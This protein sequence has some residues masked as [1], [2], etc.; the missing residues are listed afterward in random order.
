MGVLTAV[1]IAQTVQF[2]TTVRGALCLSGALFPPPR[3]RQRHHS[4]CAPPLTQINETVSGL[5][6]LQDGL[7]TIVDDNNQLLAGLSNLDSSMA[8]LRAAAVGCGQAPDGGF[9][10]IAALVQT[11]NAS[12]ALVPNELAQTISTLQSALST[13]SGV[14]SVQN[15]GTTVFVGVAASLSIYL[16]CLG[17]VGSTLVPKPCCASTFRVCNVLLIVVFLLTWI[18]AGVLMIISIVGSD[19]C[20]APPAAI[21]SIAS[22]TTGSGA[23]A[24]ATLLYYT[25]CVAADGRIIAP[26][27]TAGAAYSAYTANA[28]FASFMPALQNWTTPTFRL[29]CAVQ[30]TAVTNANGQCMN[31]LSLLG[32]DAG[33]VAINNDYQPLATTLC[34]TGIFAL[35]NVWALATFGCIFMLTL[36]AAATRICWRHP[37]DLSEEEG[38]SENTRLTS[39]WGKGANEAAAPPPQGSAAPYV[40]MASKPAPA[41]YYTAVPRSSQAYAAVPVSDWGR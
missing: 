31:A 10:T 13:G 38:D 17:L 20:A 2:K 36:T 5:Q 35:T 16:A 4:P 19:I 37:G 30:L 6:T 15:L 9:D 3:P 21:S 11:A 8:A 39:A 25:S 34:N 33:C 41:S 26:T 12:A 32:A 14:F 1:A 24:A 23:E 28:T 18:F 22:Q 27:S 40:T 29:N 7:T